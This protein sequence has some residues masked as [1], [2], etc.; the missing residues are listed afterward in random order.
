MLVSYIHLPEYFYNITWNCEYFYSVCAAQIYELGFSSVGF[1]LRINDNQLWRTTDKTGRGRFHEGPFQR[2]WLQ[3]RLNSTY[4]CWL[5]EYRLHKWWFHEC[6]SF[7]KVDVLKISFTIVHL[8]NVA[9][10][11]VSFTYVDF[12]NDGFTNA[13]STPL[14]R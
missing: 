10:T 12:T 5:Q 2:V 14:S 6:Q 3:Y 11:N 1:Q 13:H 8:T 9:F 7:S 4:E